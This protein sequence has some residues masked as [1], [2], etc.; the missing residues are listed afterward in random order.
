MIQDQLQGLILSPPETG[1]NASLWL[2]LFLCLIIVGLALWRW[3]KSQ[4]SATLKAQKSLES[5]IKSVASSHPESTHKNNLQNKQATAIKCSQILSS[6]FGV[7]HLDQYQ[8]TNADEWQHFYKKLNTLC[9]SNN[10]NIQLYPI[11]QQA[12][13]FLRAFNVADK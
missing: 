12:K 1:F 3:R 11:L 4:N 9:Y 6:G 5:L 10:S 13:S 8:P 7:K 2:G